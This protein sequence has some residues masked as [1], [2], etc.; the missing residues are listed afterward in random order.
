M[1]NLLVGRETESHFKVFLREGDHRKAMYLLG[2]S[3]TGKSTLMANM[4]LAFHAMGDGVMVVDTKDGVLTSQLAGITPRP[5]DTIYVAPGLCRWDGEWHY[6]G[7]NLLEYDK[8][9]ARQ[10]IKVADRIATSVLDI[11]E[12]MDQYDSGLMTQVGEHLEMSVRL[13]IARPGATFLDVRKV[14]TEP[15]YRQFLMSRYTVPPEVLEHWER[16]ERMTNNEKQR[17]VISTVPRIHKLTVSPVLNFMVTQEETTLRLAEWLDAGKLVLIDLAS[18]HIESRIGRTIGNLVMALA[19][20]AAFARQDAE[21]EDKRHW[22]FLVD[23]FHR[24]APEQ[25]A[26]LIDLI[27]SRRVWPVLAHQ[28]KEQLKDGRS[29]KSQLLK[30]VGG[31]PVT[32]TFDISDEDRA[33][34]KQYQGA[35]AAETLTG[36]PSHTARL[37]VRRSL[38]DSGFPL[39]VRLLPLAG[40]YREE[41][42]QRLI[43][44]QRPFTRPERE[45]AA[46]NR[47]RYYDRQGETQGDTSRSNDRRNDRQTRKSSKAQE[48]QT[49]PIPT[50]PELPS[51]TDRDDRA[52]TGDSHPPRPAPIRYRR[53][54]PDD[55]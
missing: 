38:P 55:F 11:Y 26:D 3:G 13:A 40:E 18:G 47:R 22:R 2:L 14:L 20:N 48:H 43:D 12:R 6:W 49:E 45:L 33:Y 8:E 7:I 34:V 53:S 21:K 19:V 50:R 44:A 32:F 35:E 30:S 4:A 28:N 29:H 54:G 16:F 1:G 52:G 10:G 41:Q 25:F 42:R 5:E 39:Q 17:A 24:I 23:E 15:E 36:M 46:F 9:A 51:E 37:A 27:R 31:V